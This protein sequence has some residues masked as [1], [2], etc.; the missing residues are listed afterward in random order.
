MNQD[1][2]S[3]ALD[4]VRTLEEQFVAERL[5][6]QG[7]GFWRHQHNLPAPPFNYE[8]LSAERK[9]R[10]LNPAYRPVLRR[11]DVVR[12][13]EGLP[14]VTSLNLSD[15]NDRLVRTLQ[16][17]QFVPNVQTLFIHSEG[18]DD[19][20]ALAALGKLNHLSISDSEAEDFRSLG[21]CAQV[22]TLILYT[23]R[24]WPRLTGWDGMV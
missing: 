3:W 6:E 12:A 20:S 22:R 5:V 18:I 13:A 4:P 7:L 15:S 1:F 8:K 21:H 9:Q 19:W 11:E 17:A 2:T 24:P 16:G 10:A 14:A 23:R